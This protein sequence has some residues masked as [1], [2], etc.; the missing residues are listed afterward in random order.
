ML[1]GICDAGGINTCSFFFEGNLLGCCD[2]PVTLLT[3]TT[4]S[5]SQ[6]AKNNHRGGVLVESK[7]KK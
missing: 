7:V 4:V 6:S 1:V 5:R 3:I 2:I